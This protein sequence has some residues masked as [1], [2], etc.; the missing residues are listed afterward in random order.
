[1]HLAAA[2]VMA[3]TALIGFK[4]SAKQLGLFIGA[5]FGLVGVIGLIQWPPAGFLVMIIAVM[6]LPNLAGGVH[7]GMVILVVMSLLWILTGLTQRRKFTILT[8]RTVFPLVALIIVSC[9]SFG[10]GQLPWFNFVR[11]APLPAQVGGIAIV[12]LSAAAYI[13]VADLVRDLRWLKWMTGIFLVFG[14]IIMAGFILPGMDKVVQK[15]IHGQTTG[16]LFSA[17]LAA[18]AFSQCLFNRDLGKGWRISLGVLLLAFC[19]YGLVVRFDWKSIWMPGLASIF[20]I[21]AFRYPRFGIGLFLLGLVPIWL[22]YGQFLATDEYSVSTRVEGW[23]ILAEIIKA[24]PLLGL[25]FGNY[26]YY[27]PLFSIRGFF[28]SFNSHNNYIDIIAQ[29]GLIG[30]FCFLWFTWQAG[31]TGW[32]LRNKF[33]DGFSKAYI[34]GALG[35]LV[36]TLTA[37]MLGDW[38]LPFIYNIGFGGLRN[39]LVGWMFLGGIE[40][41]NQMYLKN[42]QK[43]SSV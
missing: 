11:H 29:T 40:A 15:I 35:G 26:Y 39:G 24:N 32:N 36:G 22:G 6:T 34:Y 13:L 7:P 18:I 4:A 23:S 37:G 17:W 42:V 9:I 19:F 25:G 8:S 33:S 12:I 1:V 31:K 20:A 3:V 14:G 28:V 5:L 27:T 41:L 30:L 38:I 10:V 21:I 2:G 43:S 16:G